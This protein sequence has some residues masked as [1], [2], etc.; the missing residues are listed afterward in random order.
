VNGRLELELLVGVVA[1]WAAVVPP[2]D[3]PAPDPLLVGAAV[4]AS[5]VVEDD[6]DGH[7]VVVGALV[8]VEVVLLDEV[9]DVLEVDDVDVLVVADAEQS[10]SPEAARTVNP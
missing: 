10:L 1:T 5:I 8:L 9:D 6:G 3:S 2:L 7:V 4:V